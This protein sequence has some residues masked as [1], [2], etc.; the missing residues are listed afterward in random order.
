MTSLRHHP[1]V[2]IEEI[3]MM[4]IRSADS[5]EVELS[6]RIRRTTRSR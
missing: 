5:L 2:I 3:P 6:D 1:D 4:W